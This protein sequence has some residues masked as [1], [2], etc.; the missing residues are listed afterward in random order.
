M[1][2]P[3]VELRRLIQE[4]TRIQKGLAIEIDYVDV[5][6]ALADGLVAR[7]VR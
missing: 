3:I 4:N 7:L 2:S 6:H 5:S 1:S